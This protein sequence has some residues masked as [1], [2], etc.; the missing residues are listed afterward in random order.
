MGTYN[1]AARRAARAAAR[2]EAAAAAE[3]AG[4]EARGEI[5]PIDLGPGPDGADRIIALPAEFPLDVL[6]PLRDLGKD[7]GLLL[8]QGMDLFMGVVVDL[9]P[10]ATP[11]QR[12]AAARAQTLAGANL[13]V[14]LLAA[15]PDLPEDAINVAVT[16]GR[17]LFGDQGWAW[18]CEARLSLDDMRDLADEVGAFYGF[19]GPGLGPGESSGSSE[20]PSTTGGTSPVTSPTGTPASTPELSG[21]PQPTPGSSESAA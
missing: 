7:L 18:L 13:V 8:R 14:D 1:L 21:S 19:G 9:P 10:N 5:L 17:R 3:V 12:A 11:E 2:S 20:S 4:R 6:W 16:M 15:N